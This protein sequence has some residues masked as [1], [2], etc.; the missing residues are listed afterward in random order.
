MNESQQK[1]QEPTFRHL[2]AIFFTRV[3]ELGERPFLKL[4]QGNRSAEISWKDFGSKVRETILGLYSLGLQKGDRIGILSENRLEWLCADAATMAGGLPNVIISP[5]ISDATIRKVLN[6]SG[7]RAVFVEDKNGLARLEKLKGQLPSLAHII[8]MDRTNSLPPGSITYDDLLSRGRIGDETRIREILESVRPDDLA[9]VM[10]TSGSTGEPKGVMRT[11]ENLLSNVMGGTEILPSKPDELFLVILSLNHLLGRFGFQKSMMT[12][13]RT[14][15]VEATELDIDLKEIQALSP[16]V[17]TLVPRVMERIWENI[18]AHG[19]NRHH[20]E[21]IEALDQVKASRGSL[22]TDEVQ[23]YEAMRASLRESVNSLLGGRIQY[24]TYA[25]APMPPRILRFFEVIRIPLLGSY[26]T[27]ECGGVTLSGLGEPRPGSAGKPF[28]N[29]EVRIAEDGEIL[30]RG[31]A[32]F[33][34]YFGDPETTREALDADG[35]CHTGDLG[36]LDSDG[37]LYVVGRKK[38]IFYC[39]DGSNIYPGFIELLLEQDPFIRQAALLGDR[40]PFIAALI[41]PDRE[42][43]AAELSKEE[44]T[45]TDDDIQRMVWARVQMINEGL[46]H[47]EQVRKVSVLNGD[48]P[49]NVRS[50]TGFLQKRKVDRKEVGKLYQREIEVIYSHPLE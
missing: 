18:L 48:F 39:S 14:A 35:W 34:G 32:V 25:G 6:H 47:Y 37:Y 15:I 8:V 21:A 33:P 31:P 20:W 11:Q 46:E 44:S 7:A 45:L 23:Q 22:S 9:T 4:Q 38:D 49:Q 28:P 27:T 26:G 43:V 12:G 30:V 10:Y 24:I 13:R 5:R 36:T 29:A 40:R 2:G 42:R 19:S 41:V 1:I 16:T 50:A 17:I 3:K